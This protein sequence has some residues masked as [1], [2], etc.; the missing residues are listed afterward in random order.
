MEARAP[1]A[2][3]V[4]PS[5]GSPG[6]FRYTVPRHLSLIAVIG[7]L[8]FVRNQA[9]FCASQFVAEDSFYFYATAYN[10]PFLESLA[11]PYAGYLHVLPM[12]L[13]EFLWHLP[14]E[15]LPL[16][17]H[18]VALLIDAAC[19]SW[20]FTPSCRPLIQSDGFRLAC[21]PLLAVVPFQPNA[22]MLLGI[23]W[24]L[25]FLLTLLVLGELPQRAPAI[26][27]ACA[28]AVIG[29]WTAP[30]A[31]VL[32]PIAFARWFL[33]QKHPGRHFLLA[34]G[35]AATAHAVLAVAVFRPA[36]GSI[37][38][39]GLDVAWK[40]FGKML[41]DG[42]LVPSL[43]GTRLGYALAEGVVGDAF[44]C[45][46][47]IVFGF[48]LWL[49]R[50]GR[51]A[52]LAMVLLAVACGIL[53]LTMMR[54]HQSSLLL[55][56]SDIRLERYLTVP[57]LLMWTAILVL[58]AEWTAAGPGRGVR[59]G[60][61]VAGAG[62]AAVFHITEPKLANSDRLAEAIPHEGKVQ[63]LREYERRY[64]ERGEPETLALPGWSPIECMVLEIGGGRECDAPADL[65][66]VFGPTLQTRGERRYVVDWFG[67]FTRSEDGSIVHP[68]LGRLQVL[69]FGRGL[70]WLADD[71]GQAFLTGPAFYPRLVRWPPEGL[72]GVGPGGVTTSG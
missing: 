35:T 9:L 47:A 34:L 11:T 25:T 71:S 62:F 50:R 51:S 16:A 32:V 48:V 56:R 33:N 31:I 2:G 58:A 41:A 66:C 29:T 3:R 42:L 52:P 10:K 69:G 1:N 4:D 22:G 26:A 28:L 55:V 19:L 7:A 65:H 70:Y 8:L 39:P 36:T 60:L 38:T 67:E 20:I 44:A 6:R 18:V 40:A 13:A 5:T 57:T 27:C 63:L 45:S 37:Y 30:G 49:R 54:G 46:V 43:I 12:A 14:F 23:H 15:V 68:R 21:A 72:I 17:N 61:G 64:A 53:F 59:L 24:Y